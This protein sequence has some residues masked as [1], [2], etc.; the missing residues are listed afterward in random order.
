V[1]A[2]ADA[3]SDVDASRATNAAA[4][5]AGQV[6]GRHY[7]EWVPTLNEWRSAGR[8]DDAL[9]LLM[10]II[11]A[12]ERVALIDGLEP[13]PAYTKRVAVIFRR[14]GDLAGEID[15]LERWLAACPPDRGDGEIN[16]RL[17]RAKRRLT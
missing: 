16:E 9:D 5:E 7:V 8:D 15:V 1:H 17:A 14:R 10:E 13:P 12:T 2:A 6:R 4:E 11:D 3:V